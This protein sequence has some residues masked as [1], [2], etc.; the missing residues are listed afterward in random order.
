MHRLF[1]AGFMMA[2]LVAC[3]TNTIQ[4]PPKMTV[5]SSWQWQLADALDENVVAKVMDVDLFETDA[6]TIA[7]M[8]AKG[9]MTICYVSV[10]SWEDY[11]PDKNQFPKEVIGKDY[12]GWPGEKW[13]DIRAID[14]LAPVLRARMDQCKTKGFD[15]LEPD[16]I[17]G[18]NN[19]TGFAI[20][21]ADQIKF[22]KWL[23]DEAHARGLTI[24]LKNVNEFAAQLEPSFDWALTE[25]CFEQG[26]CND[27]KLF[28]DKG[29]PVFMTEYTD[30]ITLEQFKKEACLLAKTLKFSAILKNRNL[31]AQRETC[32]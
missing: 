21:E 26:W 32:P 8:K 14:K 11:R 17:D 19:D 10:G 27:L 24:G 29:K 3:V 18:Y 16:N 4:I 9:Q 31:D 2:S 25:G 1:I 28:T 22:I 20:T 6:A 30:A 12:D 7:R 15:A 5:S 13:L 23:A